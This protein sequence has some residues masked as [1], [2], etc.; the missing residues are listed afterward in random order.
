M[1]TFV[2]SF[3]KNNCARPGDISCFPVLYCIIPELFAHICFGS[4]IKVIYVTNRFLYDGLF[5]TEYG[6]CFNAYI[7]LSYL[8]R[9]FCLNHSPATCCNAAC[10]NNL[11]SDVLIGIAESTVVLTA[12]YVECLK[13]FDDGA[14]VEMT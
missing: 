7:R 12:G 2:R 4:C 14:T 1:H 10:P 5:V 8:R 13:R 11:F 9:S 3:G 6:C